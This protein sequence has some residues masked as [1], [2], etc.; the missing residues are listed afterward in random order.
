MSKRDKIRVGLVGANWGATHIAA[1]QSIPDVELAAI[2]TASQSS[3]ER[4]ATAHGIPQAYGDS[5]LLLADDSIDIIDVT[6]RPSIREPIVFSALRAGRHVM[7]PLP[8][9]L[10]L[11]H[12]RQLRDLAR[13]SGRVAMI[14]NLHP[15]SPAFRQG[16]AMIDSG[17][18][19]E[20]RNVRCYIRTN[21]LL[22]VPEGFS[23]LWTIDPASGASTIRNF[24][25]HALHV[26]KWMIGDVARISALLKINHPE[27]IRPDGPPVRTGTFDSSAVLLGFTNGVDGVLDISWSMHGMNDFSLDINGSKG[28]LAITAGGLGP[29]DPM[30]SFA[31]AGDGRARA[32]PID[33][34]FRAEST[35]EATDDT[36][37]ALAFW[38]QAGVAAVRRE[39]RAMPDF[40]DAYDIMQVVEAAY[41]ANEEQRWVAIDEF[42]RELGP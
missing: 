35:V 41:Q 2:C 19:G 24:G 21:M 20:L 40:D 28:R 18:I 9:A 15:Y 38:C 23:Y 11:D 31:G 8:F 16:K 33:P 36:L 3:A 29:R 32:I 30:V 39:A 10:N 14:E 34:A 22:N 37:E 17:E 25:S 27:V 6:T 4:V 7:Q 1:W 5:D 12:G 26:M 42:R 13:A